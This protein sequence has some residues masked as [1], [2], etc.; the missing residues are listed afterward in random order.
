LSPLGRYARQ[1]YTPWRRGLL[2]IP[3]IKGFIN[4]AWVS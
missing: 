2:L 3:R 4:Y 1:G